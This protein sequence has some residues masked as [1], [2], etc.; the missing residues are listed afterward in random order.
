MFAHHVSCQLRPDVTMCKTVVSE[1]FKVSVRQ[2][3]GFTGGH[4]SVHVRQQG[5]CKTSKLSLH[6]VYVYLSCPSH[7]HLFSMSFPSLSIPPLLCPQLYPLDNHYFIFS[8]SF[9]YPGKSQLST[10]L[11]SLH[12]FFKPHGSRSRW[13]FRA[14][15]EGTVRGNRWGSGEHYSFDSS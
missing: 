4:V 5:R 7:S 9:I 6:L 14:L 11:T 15:L 1:Q 13:S 3:K 8:L 2:L 12:W 10:F